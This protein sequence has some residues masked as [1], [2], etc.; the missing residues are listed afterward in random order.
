MRKI[1]ALLVTAFMLFALAACLGEADEPVRDAV[2]DT[3]T[4]VQTE[5]EDKGTVSDT[6]AATEETAEDTADAPVT[7]SDEETEEELTEPEGVDV[8]PSESESETSESDSEE[9][10]KE[11][12]ADGEEID[13]S[14]IPPAERQTGKYTSMLTGLPTTKEL[15]TQRP[16]AVMINNIKKSLPQWGLSNADIIYECTVEG[17]LTR[18]MAVFGD[19]ASVGTIGSVRSSREYY[20]DFAAN[21]NAI[22][23]HAGGSEEAYIQ[24][25]KRVINNI[26]GVNM[27]VPDCFYRDEERKTTMGYEHSLM[28][29]GTRIA[30]AIKFK[31]YNTEVYSYFQS[32]FRFVDYYANETNPMTGGETA[33]HVIIHYNT[34]HFPQYIYN[35]LTNTYKR[36]QYNG[37]AHIDAATGE[38][39]EFTNILI[40]SLPHTSRNDEKNHIDVDTVGSGDGWYVSG[41]K[42]IKIKWEKK[43]LDIPM[44]LYNADGT[45]LKMN[46]GKTFVNIVPTYSF[47]K[48]EINHTK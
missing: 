41:G 16:A 47:S 32:S 10:P 17:G 9:T 18:L 22:Y 8:E 42:A 23:V 36:Y 13:V 34:S 44:V 35:S 4:S 25:G 2:T 39:L 31:K 11:T 38:T 21:H 3:Q 26:D 5:P 19:Y 43:N 12:D 6:E 40:L 1:T 37:I 29:D 28:T 20:L 30:N 45:L 48:I 33:K 15:Y 7:L 24:I 14:K 46:C 27:Y